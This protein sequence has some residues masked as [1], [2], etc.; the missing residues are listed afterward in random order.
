MRCTLKKTVK[1]IIAS[2]NDYLMAVKPNQPKLF[3]HLRTQFEQ[4]LPTSSDCQVE[5]TRERTTS[6]TVRVLESVAGIDPGWVGVERIVRVERVGTR[7]NQ[8]YTQTMF[9]ISSLKLDAA[10]FAQHIR[11]HWHIEN[12]LHWPKDVVLHEDEA[13]LCDGHAPTNFAIVRTIAINLFR[14][15][16]FA[17]ITKGLRHLA[18]DI[19]RLFSF[20]Q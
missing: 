7:D 19:P 15:A 18:H 12:R 5:R 13:P 3:G 4:S 20:F 16:G 11:S 1:Q 8:P 10:G 6:R 14:Q 9:Y 17:S 2:G